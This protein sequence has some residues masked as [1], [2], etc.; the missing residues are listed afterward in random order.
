MNNI[1]TNN[2]GQLECWAVCRVTRDGGT[3]P[4]MMY[5]SFQRASDAMYQVIELFGQE[6]HPFCIMDM[7]SDVVEHDCS[8]ELYKNEATKYLEVK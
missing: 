7:N 2:D 6:F 8:P 5:P 1:E 3:K 4:I